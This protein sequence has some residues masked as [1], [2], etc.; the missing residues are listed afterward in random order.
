MLTIQEAMKLPAMK[1]TKLIAGQSG[2]DR[3]IKWITTIEIIE[4]ISRFQAGEFIV[5]TGYGL[6]KHKKY[7][8]RMIELIQEN[9]LSGIAIYTGFYLDTIPPN[10]LVASDK[11]GLPI[12]EIPTSINFSTITKAIVEQIGNQQMRLLED[13]LNIH[14]EMT[15]LALNNGGLN[16]VLQKLSPLT[17]SSLVVFDDLGHR[18][19]SQVLSTHHIHITEQHITVNNDTRDLGDIFNELSYDPS[20]KTFTL[21]GCHCFRSTIKA[22]S[23]TY[24]YLLAIHRKEVW[25]EMDDIIM[26]H[27]ST[28]IGIELV[29]QY[30]VE[31]TRVRLQG[32]L[33]EEIIMKE[34]L[35]KDVTMKRGKKLGYDLTKPQAALFFKFDIDEKLLTISEDSTNHL[36]YVVSQSFQKSHRQ[37]I[38]LPKTNSLFALI[39]VDADN[40]MVEKEALKKIAASIHER[41]SRHFTFPIFIGIGSPYEDLHH[42][43]QSAKEAEYAVL[44]SPLLLNNSSIVH[45][46]EL[47][48]YQMLI[49]MQ[50]SGISLEL[51]YEKYLGN[52]ISKKQHRTDLLLT[53][54]TFLAHNCNIQQ[55]ASHLYI[56]RHTLKY[57]LSQIEKRTGYSLQSPDDRMN[58]HLAILAY[59]LI[60]LQKRK[61]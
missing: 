58:L 24:G 4:D 49:Q 53:L 21:N 5:T 50:E 8:E 7:E 11:H 60:T 19:A 51:F 30:A 40:Q 59:K 20:Q 33:V 9:Q 16:E 3:A 1:G 31:E 25:T 42:I 27:V 29:K 12:I 48:F 15:K 22:E 57:R 18:L 32:E 45:F 13:S 38:L 6:E 43:S 17:N 55:T 36:H 46:D 26:D 61:Q 54:E 44:Y 2:M 35:N 34:Q 23:F 14:K 28:L 41:W 47:G 52:V 10:I 37:H 39:E 56:H